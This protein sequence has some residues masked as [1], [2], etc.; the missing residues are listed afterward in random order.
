MDYNVGRTP[1]RKMSENT[2]S[3]IGVLFRGCRNFAT[4]F[5]TLH[6]VF[7]RKGTLMKI[8]PNFVQLVG[9][10]AALAVGLLVAMTMGQTQAVEIAYE[11]F[12]YTTTNA[13]G[14]NYLGIA[15]AASEE[16]IDDLGIFDTGT[17][18]GFDDG[19]GSVNINTNMTDTLLGDPARQGGSGSWLSSQGW[20]MRFP[21]NEG[22]SAIDATSSLQY[23]DSKGN[24]LK[25]AQGKI[26][27]SG[28]ADGVWTETWRPF[29]ASTVVDPAYP[30]GI[31]IPS[32]GAEEIGGKN[33]GATASRPE[34]VP[35]L[36]KQGTVIWWSFLSDRAGS[37]TTGNNSVQLWNK[38]DA[39]S[40]PGVADRTGGIFFKDKGNDGGFWQ[41]N[42]G[43]ETSHPI[44]TT[45]SLAGSGAATQAGVVFVVAKLDYS[46]T[47][48][49]STD[50]WAAITTWI[51]PDL[52]VEP[53]AADGIA[54]DGYIP[55]NAFYVNSTG[56]GDQSIDE[57]RLG[58]TWADVAP[59]AGAEAPG[60]FDSDGDV[61]GADFL[62]WQRG[63]ATGGTTAANLT[64]WE[65]NFGTSAAGAST[66]AVPEPTSICLLG[67]AGV[68]C[69]L[70][71][72]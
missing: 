6:F 2:I 67:I 44:G 20:T 39:A 13:N 71:R 18:D 3:M 10:K 38:R 43:A 26:D 50:G 37:D 59:I 34:G 8:K 54:S 29:D 53:S 27:Y 9:A 32:T 57:L 24:A 55:F 12:N 22:V 28:L 65:N 11:G 35:T 68:M 58:T 72:R 45:V 14:V 47:S 33:F 31:S 61:D 48:G 1:D 5:C 41:G 4:V 64:L 15:D 52:D 23:S 25:T 51:N 21:G 66:G 7:L 42:T 70:R 62:A 63:N 69:C 36:G 49:S 19:T 40:A 30:A 16:D 46:A 56:N 17:Y 60:D